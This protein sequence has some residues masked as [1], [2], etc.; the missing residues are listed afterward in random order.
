MLIDETINDIDNPTLELLEENL[1][2]F[3]WALVLVT[4]YRYML[5]RVSTTVLGL[6]GAGGA[7]VYADYSQW[8]DA[9]SQRRPAARTPEKAAPAEVAQ[10][11]SARSANKKKLSY[12]DQREWDQMEARISEAEAEL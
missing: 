12:L 11:G 5:D 8:E 3:T 4:H 1:M 2:A 10:N 6:D 9:R 7:Q